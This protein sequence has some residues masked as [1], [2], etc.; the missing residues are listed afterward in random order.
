MF[1]ALVDWVE[2]GRAPEGLVSVQENNG[3]KRRSRPICAYPA[4]PRYKGRG[5]PELAS[6]F[7]CR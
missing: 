3:E 5:D 2:K 7:R 4:L 6:S 1:D